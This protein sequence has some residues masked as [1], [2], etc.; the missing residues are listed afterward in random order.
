MFRVFAMPSPA[1][2]ASQP[3]A[4]VPPK[5]TQPEEGTLIRKAPKI[6]GSIAAVNIGSVFRSQAHVERTEVFFDRC[7]EMPRHPSFL[8]SHH[9][10]LD[11]FGLAD[12]FG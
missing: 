2:A 10:F 8:G 6:T 1:L 9:A 7:G 11:P 3:A 5:V 12:Q 4:S